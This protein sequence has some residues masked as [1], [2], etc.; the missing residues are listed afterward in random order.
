MTC[1]GIMTTLFCS[2]TVGHRQLEKRRTTA[3]TSYHATCT[4]H[5]KILI[6]GIS[7]KL[8]FLFC[9]SNHFIVIQGIDLI[10][11]KKV[12]PFGIPTQTLL[13]QQVTSTIER[14]RK[15]YQY[16]ALPLYKYNIQNANIAV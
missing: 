10:S 9:G 11:A 7:L 16:N 12:K 2:M 3:E 5:R 1:F 13:R 15:L 8:Q 14:R 4:Q 6:L